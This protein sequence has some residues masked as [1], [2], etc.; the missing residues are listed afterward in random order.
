MLQSVKALRSAPELAREKLAPHLHHYLRE[1]ILPSNWYP[2]EDH[3]A[4]LIALTQIFPRSDV[5]VWELFGRTAAK[6]DLTS[7]YRSTVVHRTMLGTLQALV[8]VFH[9]Y[10]DTGR[11]VVSGDEHQAEMDIFDYATVSADHCRFLS[12]YMKEYLEM[13]FGQPVAIRE[14][15]CCATGADRCRRQ[16]KRI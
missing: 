6:H 2:E 8:Q 15:L 10:H 14:T 11:L 12:G 5:D 3:L 4:L 7:I 9:L 1:R 13:S 16:F